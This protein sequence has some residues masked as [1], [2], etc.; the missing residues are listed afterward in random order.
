MK[1][2]LLI[3]VVFIIWLT[4]CTKQRPTP[5]KDLSIRLDSLITHEHDSNRFDGTIVVGTQDSILFQRAIG[6][7]NRVWD[8]PMRMDSRFDICSLDKS[9][10]ATLVLMAVEEGKLSLDDHLTDLLKPLNY[11]GAFDPNIT[12]HQMLTHTSGLAHYE[13]MAPNLQLDWFRPFKRKHFNNPEYIDFISTV[14]TVNSP[15]KQFY[16]SS[17]AY[18]LLAIILED[19]YQQ[20]YAELL[21]EKICQPLEL[22]QTFSTSDNLEVHKHMVEAYNY[23]ELS[24]SWKRN[25]F[26]DLTLGRRIFSTS[27]DLYLWGKAMSAASLL[28]PESMKRMHSN[29][30]KEITP[31]IS[32]GYGWAVFDK[33]GNY[34]MGNLGID[35]KYIIHGGATE[36]FRSMLVNIENGQYIIA[37][38]TNI[39]DQVNEIEITKKIANI[40]IESKYD[41]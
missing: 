13:H 41:N 20:P 3:S 40:L 1:R 23:H 24:D 26:I 12:I 32:Y 21:N 25:Q 16:Y 11:S 36:G 5:I 8:I 19:I 33:K 4:S 37:F 9:F 31:D 17:F 38:L 14:P 27:H 6:T 18:H 15:G 7:A 34:H 10:T 28:S 2:S 35:Q 30:L 29:Y 22:R 39:G